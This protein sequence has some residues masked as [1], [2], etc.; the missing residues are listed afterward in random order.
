MSSELEES[1]AS[2]CHHCAEAEQSGRGVCAGRHGRHCYRRDQVENRPDRAEDQLNLNPWNSEEPLDDME[3]I[4]HE[5]DAGE[6][7]AGHRHRVE[8]RAACEVG[9]LRCENAYEADQ[10]QNLKGGLWMS[11]S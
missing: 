7:E 3:Q 8:E 4:E 11:Q 6:P 9:V 5:Q 2:I 10:I 1:I